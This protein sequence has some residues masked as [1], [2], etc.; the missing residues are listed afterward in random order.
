MPLPKGKTNKMSVSF[1][2]GMHKRPKP[3]IAKLKKC[4]LLGPIF[5]AIGI[6]AKATE[7]QI[8]L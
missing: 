4:N 1:S 2:K 6:S 5:F 8:I 3:P 7:K